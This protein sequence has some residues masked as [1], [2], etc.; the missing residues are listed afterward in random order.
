MKTFL[1]SHFLSRE[2]SWLEFNQRVLNEALSP[3]NPLL[4]RVK[5]FTITSSNLDEF[6]EVRVAGLKQQ[7]ESDVV[8]RS[9]DGRTA[10][11][12]FRA[13]TKR[14][15]QMIDVQYRCWRDEL[16]PALAR[17]GI[18]FLTWEKLQT[19][20]CDFLEDYY[21]R[22]VRPVLTPLGVDPSHP[23][24]QLLNKSLNIAVQL[25]IERN[26]EVQSRLAVVQV[27]RV[28]PRLVKLPRDDDKQDYVFMGHL[29]GHYLADLFP[30]TTILGFWHFR[31][32]R[33]SEL[34]IDEEDVGNLLSAVEQELHNRRK[35]AAV[36]LEVD[37]DCPADIYHNLLETLDLTD[38]D[39]YIIDGPLNP[40]RLMAVYE[41]DHSPELRDKP[42]VAPVVAALRDGGDIF[43]V[44]RKRD[45]LIHH[46]YESFSSVVDFLEQAS[47][48]PNVLAIK[49]TLYRT[50]GDPR[51]VGALMNAVKNGKQVTAVT[52][53]KARFDEANNI[54]W[55]K[56][57]E[58]AGVHVVYGIVNHKVHSKVALVVRRDDD[59]L[60]RYVH[61]GTGNYNPSTARLYTDISLLTAHPD[62]GEDATNF[63]NLL[64]GIC[65]FQGAR[66][67]LISPFTT[68][69][70]MMSR[71]KREA[72]NALAKKPA[73][74]I[75]K[76]NALVDREII[77]ALYRASQAGV[78]IDL[79]I[80]GIC[81]LR[82]GLPGISENITVRSIVGRF[83]E[84]SRIFYFQNG[85]APEVFVGSADW[86]PRNFF[87]RIEVLFPIEDPTLRDR[88]INQILMTL[89]SDTARASVLGSDGAYTLLGGAKESE[90]RNSQSEFMALALGGSKPRK[91]AKAARAR[92]PRISVST[93]PL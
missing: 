14:V 5:F 28:L 71:I 92:F 70:A 67:F 31:V 76:M 52:E 65:Q 40:I 13:I 78:K 7:I 54:L 20:D 91:K 93:R 24:P 43:S 89:L 12:T 49:Q 55:A 25:E 74:I 47:R 1:A 53:L 63:F 39:L 2:L 72:E 15:R 90:R 82:P 29:I 48:D 66:K 41:G 10:T 6:F 86:M 42:F 26:G 59:G 44:V 79:I 60:R 75:A 30:G 64:T 8:E 27:P 61:L 22:R 45:V 37:V 34:Y 33:N 84:H 56:R 80:R 69:D 87:R 51:I 9:I 46:P 23:F 62:Y 17:N 68:H 3:S 19:P 4:E 35:G 83:L 32:T 38:E 81:C 11:E 50:G 58:E 73:R 36:R 85:T 21:H 16:L 77:E 57:L 18:R 88:V